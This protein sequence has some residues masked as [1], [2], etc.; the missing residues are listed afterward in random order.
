MLI[1]TGLSGAALIELDARLPVVAVA[2]R[3]RGV[4]SVRSDDAGG[5]ALAV[6]YL[7]DLGHRAVLHVDGARGAG[8]TDRRKGFSK[9]AAGAG[10]P[11]LCCRVG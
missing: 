8:S 6:D 10:S 5:A 2:R 1:G 7:A 11:P 3:V 4:D 9:A